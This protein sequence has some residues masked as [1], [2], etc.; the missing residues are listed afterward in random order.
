MTEGDT[1]DEGD[2]RGHPE[3]RTR[4]RRTLSWIWLA[5]VFAAAVVLWLAWRSLAENG[6]AIVIDFVS[7][8]G[9][10]EGQTKIRYKGVDVGTVES[11]ELSRDMSRVQVHA[12]MLTTARIARR[13]R[14]T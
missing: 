2:E 10:Q 3:A 8:E 6:P 7:A 4:A 13:R 14:P 9:M 11:L 1:A 5:P 12:R